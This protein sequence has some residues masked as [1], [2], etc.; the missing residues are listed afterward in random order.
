MKRYVFVFLILFCLFY[1]QK[2]KVSNLTQFETQFKQVEVKGEVIHP[3]VYEV[4]YHATIADVLEEAGGITEDGDTSHLN[5]TADI[6]NHGVVVVSE[7]QLEEKISLN[8]ATLEELDSLKGIGPAIA[9]RI[10]DYRLQSPFQSIEEIME[11]KG[12]GEKLFAK[13]K[14]YICL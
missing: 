10:I 5:L 9:Q 12:I 3:G 7:K 8:A 6:E 11:V 2:L 14:D 4:A 13:I 1:F